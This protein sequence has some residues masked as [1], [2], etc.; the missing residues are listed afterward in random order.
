MISSVGAI[1]IECLHRLRRGELRNAVII[2]V[3]RT[4]LMIPPASSGSVSLNRQ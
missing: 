4:V 3:K 1:S 2:D